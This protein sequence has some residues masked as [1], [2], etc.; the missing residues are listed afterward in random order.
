MMSVN[1]SSRC[2]A[3]SCNNASWPTSARKLAGPSPR[4]LS[5]KRKYHIT[6]VLLVKLDQLLTQWLKPEKRKRSTNN[7]TLPE[8]YDMDYMLLS[9]NRGLL[10][11]QGVCAHEIYSMHAKYYVY[12]DAVKLL[13]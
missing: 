10:T 2:A 11:I 8:Y 13:L 3:G 4:T 9:A 12:L 5:V 7:A 1:A 6:E